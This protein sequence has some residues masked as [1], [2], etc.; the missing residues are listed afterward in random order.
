MHES[1]VA[2]PR[3]GNKGRDRKAIAIW[4]TLVR[5]CGEAIATGTWLDVGCGSGGIA[6]TLAPRVHQMVGIDPEPW[7]DWVTTQAGVS[8]LVFHVGNFDQ[9]ALPVPEHTVD[10]AVC[11]Q[12]YEHVGDA[13]ALVRNIYRVLTPGGCCYFAGPNLLWP[14]EPHVFWPFVHWLPRMMARRVMRSLGASNADE[15]DAYS[16]HSWQLRRW[17]TDAGFVVESGLRARIAAGL[18]GGSHDR[19]AAWVARTPNRVFVLV[20]PFAPGLV[21]IL[22]K[23]GAVS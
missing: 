20:E 15:L 7:P 5:H 12:V 4:H 1:A 17:F 19:L 18:L 8:N 11:N 10:V 16:T 2:V 9:D 23:P 13:A 22:H 3:W 6:A 21:F 14:V